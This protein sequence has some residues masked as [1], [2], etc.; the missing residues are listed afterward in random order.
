MQPFQGILYH[1]TALGPTVASHSTTPTYNT[2]TQCQ[3]IRLPRTNFPAF[4]LPRP[5][6]SV[7]IDLQL[8]IGEVSAE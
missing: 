1:G 5:V 4:Q 2:G 8:S 3:G 7:G 6:E